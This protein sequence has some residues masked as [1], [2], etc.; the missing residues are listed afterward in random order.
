MPPVLTQTSV[1][2][3]RVFKALVVKSIGNVFCQ[4]SSHETVLWHQTERAF[5]TRI[6]S[7]SKICADLEES[8]KKK[9]SFETCYSLLVQSCCAS[10]M[11][12]RGIRFDSRNESAPQQHRNTSGQFRT[13][14]L[15][16]PV[17]LGS[18]VHCS[19]LFGPRG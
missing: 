1:S 7:V 11:V 17:G 8:D 6:K 4:V 2:L 14:V 5:V 15:K 10:I 9:L 13:G 19:Q 12:K 16:Y 3:L 18:T